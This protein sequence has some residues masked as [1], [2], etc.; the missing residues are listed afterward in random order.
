MAIPGLLLL[1]WLI[2]LYP[3]EKRLTTEDKMADALS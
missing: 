3:D 2:R 1:L